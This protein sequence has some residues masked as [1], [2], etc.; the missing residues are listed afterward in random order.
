MQTPSD[1]LR[2]YATL[3]VNIYSHVFCLDPFK[4]ALISI[5]TIG[6]QNCCVSLLFFLIEQT[7]PSKC[8]V[9]SIEFDQFDPFLLPKLLL[10]IVYSKPLLVIIVVACMKNTAHKTSSGL[11][12]ARFTPTGDRECREHHGLKL[13]LLCNQITSDSEENPMPEEEWISLTPTLEKGTLP[14]V[15][16]TV[17]QWNTE[18]EHALVPHN[19]AELDTLVQDLRN[20]PPTPTTAL[21][22]PAATI[23]KE[24]ESH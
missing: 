18:Y 6:V 24:Q 11:P 16:R 9:V 22:H 23:T 15:E 14:I 7:L 12:Q 17:T 1:W 13:K 5:Q 10:S 21:A 20:N 3:F 8:I 19:L 2:Q 4:I